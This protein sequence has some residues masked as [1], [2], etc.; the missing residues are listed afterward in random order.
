MKTITFY[1]YKGGVGR[2]LALSNI[3][4]RLSEF[5]KS[6]CV[7]D[8][9]LEAPGLQFKFN[10]YAKSQSIDNGIVDYISEF[11]SKGTVPNTVKDYSITL[12]PPNELF[13]PI[14]FIP[15]GNVDNPDYWKK[16]SAINWGEMFYKPSSNGVKFFLDLKKKINNEFNPDFFLIDS[17]TG[18][19]DISGITL[20]I[21]ADEI[22]IFAANNKENLYGSKK[23]IESLTNKSDLLFGVSPK[24]NFILTRLPFTDTIRDKEKEFKIVEKEKASCYRIQI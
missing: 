10:D 11:S 19:T 22:V 4:I 2:S 23:I 24:L 12:I 17:R 8:F 21:L 14:I 3:A 18:I 20:K 13:K 1:S 7:L 15:A 5:N 6:V 16:L 9:D